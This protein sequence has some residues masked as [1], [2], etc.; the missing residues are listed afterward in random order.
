MTRYLALL[1]LA[2]I[3]LLASILRVTALEK[4]PV[5]FNV[6]EANQG[7]T[8]F[9][10]LKTGRDEWGEFFPIAPRSFGDFRAP[11]YT[12]LAIPSVALLGLNILAVRLPSVLFG[13]LSVVG[14]Y[15]LVVELFGG[16]KKISLLGRDAVIDGRD[17]GLVAAVF[18]A[19]SP[20]HVQLSRGAFEANLPTFF[21]PF[22]WWAFEKGLKEGRWMILSSCFFG[23][24]LFSYYSARIIIPI[25]VLWLLILRRKTFTNWGLGGTLRKYK[26]ALGAGVIFL[27]AAAGTMFFGAGTR[28]ADVAI[29]SP[30]GGWRAVF[31]SRYEGV[32]MGEPALMAK[33]FWNKLTYLASLFMANYLSYFSPQFL[34]TEGASEATYGMIPGMGLLSLPEAM[35]VLLGL[36]VLARERLWKAYPYNMIMVA[37]LLAPVPAALAKGPGLAANRVA[38]MMPYIQIFSA[39]GAMVLWGRLKRAIGGS[40][41]AAVIGFLLLISFASSVERYVYHGPMATAPQMSYGWQEAADYISKYEGAYGGVVVSRGFSEPQ[42]FV[43]F[44]LREDP[45]F[46]QEQSRGWLR[47]EEEGLKFVDQLGEY[48]LGKFTF[49]RINYASDSLDGHLLLV[50]RGEELPADKNLLKEIDYPDGQPAIRISKG[51]GRPVGRPLSG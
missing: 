17:L 3:I 16:K 26:W 33:L 38:I 50:G 13:T 46:F 7:Y 19:I 31:G 20:W 34:F 15:L 41:A 40:Q 8:A 21:L 28:E 37:I 49:R 47:Y 42:M 45:A 51:N 10:I 12:Y 1:V 30:T 27:G 4:Y 39:I 14:T 22:G 29:F 11:L 6:D 9:S 43:A 44:F 23:L 5:G 24:G 18:L 36:Y 2:G 48:S 32:L 35:F 25:F